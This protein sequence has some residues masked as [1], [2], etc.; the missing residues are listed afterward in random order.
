MSGGPYQHKWRSL[1]SGD[2]QCSVCGHVA[3]APHDGPGCPAGVDMARHWRK[4]DQCPPASGQRD[5]EK[6]AQELHRMLREGGE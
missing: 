1:P 4:V 6:A 5:A 2:A 3:A